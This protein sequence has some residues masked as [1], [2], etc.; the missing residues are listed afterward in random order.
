MEKAPAKSRVGEG[1]KA[2]GVLVWV[3]VRRKLFNGT[4]A[5]KIITVE[6]RPFILKY[7]YLINVLELLFLKQ[8]TRAFGW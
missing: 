3:F 8:E 6:N 7:L 2:R 4:A 1:N 5:K